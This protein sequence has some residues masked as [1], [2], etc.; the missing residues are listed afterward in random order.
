MIRT[1]KCKKPIQS[2]VGWTA[3]RKLCDIYELGCS[4]YA[5]DFLLIDEDRFD[6]Q[7]QVLIV[8]D[9]DDFVEYD[10]ITLEEYSANY[11]SI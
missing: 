5:G 9:Y 2:A 6:P 1:V 10:F 4:G 8:Q 3:V 7:S 11:E